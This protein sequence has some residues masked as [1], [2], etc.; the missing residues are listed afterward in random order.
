MAVKGLILYK[1]TMTTTKCL[2]IA[3]QHMTLCAYLTEQQ[4]TM[5]CSCTN[6]QYPQCS[7]RLNM[8]Y[9]NNEQSVTTSCRPLWTDTHP[10]NM[11]SQWPD[12]RKSALV[13]NSS[14]VDEPA[15]RQ[16]GFNLP[17]HYWALLNRFQT[18]QGHCASCQKKWG[19]A[20]TNM[21]PCGKCQTMSHIVNSCPQSKLEG[22]AAIALSWRHCY[23]M[24][25]DIQI[26]NA[27]DNNNIP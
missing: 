19:L 5:T 21:C 3:L 11:I 8:S 15:I 12:E 20:T 1:Q 14:L 2:V 13:V 16:P 7:F 22:A 17:R 6:D 9:L 23:R 18:N 27:L 25:E 10:T 4:M 26:V 24:A